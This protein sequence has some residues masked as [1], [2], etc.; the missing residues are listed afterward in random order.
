MSDRGFLFLFSL[1]MIVLGL[2]SAVWLF[3]TGQADTV[4]GLFMLLT[5]GLIAAAFGI[6]VLYVIRRALEEATPKPVPAAK[7]GA[8][9]PAA[10]RAPTPAAQ[11]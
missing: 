4:D 2:A 9:A 3:A 10:K 1:L 7:A 11:A 6:Y 8:P 5:A